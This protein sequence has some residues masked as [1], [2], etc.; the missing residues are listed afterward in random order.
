[1][2]TTLTASRRPGAPVGAAIVG[3]LELLATDN[4][5]RH[6]QVRDARSSTMVGRI[7]WDCVDHVWRAFDRSGARIAE[8]ST[9]VGVANAFDRWLADT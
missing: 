2:T 7:V 1:M 3:R 6:Y 9:V 8:A 5:G 4:V